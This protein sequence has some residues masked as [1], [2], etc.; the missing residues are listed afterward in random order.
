MPTNVVLT[1]SYALNERLRQ[2]LRDFVARGVASEVN[3][4]LRQYG[5]PE[6]TQVTVA[7]PQPDVELRCHLKA[8]LSLPAEMITGNRVTP[9]E[10]YDIMMFLH[11]RLI[12]TAEGAFGGKTPGRH[13]AGTY[14]RC[15]TE[16]CGGAL[17]YTFNS[18]GIVCLGNCGFERYQRD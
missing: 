14:L 17:N 15:P 6:D 12:E 8:E 13:L 5:Y 1:P 18:N 16:S 11:R 2:A 4:S 10:L 9:R 7:E 3:I